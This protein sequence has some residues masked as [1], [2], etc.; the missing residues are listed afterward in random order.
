[1]VAIPESERVDFDDLLGSGGIFRKMLR[2]NSD[3]AQ[4]G[5]SLSLF[6]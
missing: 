5:A 4:V 2:T 1:M 6:V 3:G